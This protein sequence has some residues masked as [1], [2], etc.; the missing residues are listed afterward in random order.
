MQSYSHSSIPELNEAKLNG[1][2]HDFLFHANGLMYCLTYPDQ[3]YGINDL[4]AIAIPCM[5]LN[6]TLYLISTNDG[7]CGT[8]IEYHDF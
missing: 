5:E 2:T 3:H 7:V 8:M 1:F 6:A 4:S